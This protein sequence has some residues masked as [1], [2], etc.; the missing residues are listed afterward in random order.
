M[1]VRKP[2]HP[3]AMLLAWRGSIITAIWGRVVAIGLLAVMASWSPGWLH[4]HRPALS[5]AP[6]SLMGLV[7][8]IFLGFRNSACYDRWWEARKQWGHL[9][10]ETRDLTRGILVLLPSD[11]ARTRRLLYRAIG[12]AACL[13]ARLRDADQIAALDPWLGRDEIAAIMAIRN[14]PMAVLQAISTELVAAFRQG[15][16]GEIRFSV[17]EAHVAEMNAVQAA[18]ER[19]RSTPAPFAYTLLLHRTCWI[20]CVLVPFGLASACGWFA[21]P[22]AMV[23]AY[24]FFGLD[25]LG[26][27]LEE[28]FGLLANDLPLDALVRTIE[29]DLREALGE[30]DLPPPLAPVNDRLT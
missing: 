2:S 22:I 9:V 23:L 11:Q 10:A 29:I 1:I 12:F 28:P 17:L 19:I 15:E 3:L 20:F 13:A 27:E 25:A 4:F 7:L 14:R 6:F 16:L 18:C 30:T 24:A 21:P 26:D 5:L 8:S